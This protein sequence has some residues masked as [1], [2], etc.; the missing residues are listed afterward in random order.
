MTERGAVAELVRVAERLGAPVFSEPGTTH[1][2]LGFPS[3]HP[4]YAQGLPLWSPEIRQT[5]AEFDVLL[6]VGMDLF[7]Q[8]VYHEPACPM[9][10]HIR[11]VH[12]DEDPYQLGKNYPLAAAVWG[13]TRGGLAAI[14][15]ALAERMT[16]EQ[17]AAAR[18]TNR[19]VWPSPPSEPAN[20]CAAR[21]LPSARNGL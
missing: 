21:R 5:L 7:R 12:L 6:V 16:A 2:R 20:N 1:G 8:Y 11:L 3:D 14:D 15:A 4:L 9:P 18:I 10:E 19:A 17:I 13:S